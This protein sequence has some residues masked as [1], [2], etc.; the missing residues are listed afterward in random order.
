MKKVK[1]YNSIWSVDRVLYSINDLKLPFPVTFSQIGWFVGTELLIMT[2]AHTFPLS[3]IEGAFLKY[4]GIPVGITW[5][6]SQKTFDGKKP[7]RYVCTMLTYFMRNRT[8]FGERPVKLIKKE[9]FDERIT[10][11]RSEKYVSDK[12]HGKQSDMEQ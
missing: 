7:Y 5:F 6:M 12:V 9:K 4:L 3:M 11:V 8:T 2:F 1:S 10:Y